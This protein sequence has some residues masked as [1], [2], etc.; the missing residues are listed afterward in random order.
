MKLAQALRLSG[1]SAAPT[2]AFVGA[3][4]KTT[5]IFQLARQF[6]PPVLVTT[7]THLGTWQASLADEHYTL[8][9]PTPF[10]PRGVTLLSGP[11][12]AD[13]RLSGLDLPLVSWLREIHKH[14]P[15]LIEADGARQKMLKAPGPHEPVIPDFVDEVMVVASLKGL[16]QPLEE[17][18]VHRAEQFS[19]LSGLALGEIIT[20]EA[21]LRVLKHPQGGLKNIPPTARRVALLTQAEN[22]HLQALGK[23]LA[24]SLL[25]SFDAVLI[26]DLVNEAVFAVHEPVAAVILAA[27]ESRR[28]GKP[29]P[30]L[31]WQG[32]PFIRKVVQSAGQAGLWPIVVVTGAHAEGVEKALEGLPVQ[33]ARNEAWRSGQSTSIRLGVETLASRG[34]PT[35]RLPISEKREVGAAIFLLADQPQ[36]S[37]TVLQALRERHAETLAPIVAP[38][39]R[40]QRANPV[41]FDRQTFADLCTLEGDVG[42]RALFSRYAVEYLPWHDERL[43]LDV[44]TP[45]D[46]QR[47]LDMEE[48]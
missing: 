21:L 14:I 34:G 2:I 36:V 24:E 1:G 3:G 28:L 38:L 20:L 46:Y 17:S 25:D 29:K 42:G 47:L 37:P 10:T 9:Q 19:R 32:E 30:L 26:T 35:F 18:H 23:R 22:G 43:L 27:G 41:L 7:T 48:K 8:T 33:I 11:P 31:T 6:P 44:D 4:G 13:E 12:T 15:L 5:A 45:E 39:V 40:G 16:A